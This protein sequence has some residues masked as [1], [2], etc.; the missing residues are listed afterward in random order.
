M[1]SI[2]LSNSKIKVNF[3]ILIF[4]YISFLY[5]YLGYTLIS[6][7]IV[8]IHEISHSIV[9]IRLGYKIEKIELFPFGGVVRLNKLI[10]I[11]PY[12][13]IL[14]AG[15]GPISNIIMAIIA[16]LI[17]IR[18][19]INH[20]LLLYFIYANIIITITNLLPILPLDGGRV[21][22]AYLSYLIGMKNS[23]KVIIYISKLASLGVF[24]LGI[25]LSRY[26]KLNIMISLVAIFLYI[27]VRKEN[28]MAVFIFMREI[29]EKKHF[30]FNNGVLKTKQFVAA[31]NISIKNVLNRFR[32]QKYH[33][34]TV[35]DKEYNVLGV[36]TESEIINGIFEY[37]LNAK[38]EKLLIDKKRW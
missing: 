22:R 8:I 37:G 31:D 2:N 11:N 4:I 38:L 5:G 3:L 15:A 18:Y 26:N 36:L 17:V 7:M 34:V 9:S 1:M 13:E 32:P 6:F 29:I 27:S 28:E 14:I 24:I 19:D 25:I 21:I 10:G 33:I 23:T 20:D 16:Y 30:L 35:L 12:H